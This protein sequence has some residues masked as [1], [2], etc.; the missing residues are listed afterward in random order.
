MAGPPAPARFEAAFFVSRV[1]TGS[2]WGVVVDVSI[3]GLRLNTEQMEPV[4]SQHTLF[5]IW[6]DAEFEASVEVVRHCEGGLAVRFLTTDSDRDAAIDEIIEGL[7]PRRGA[8][9]SYGDSE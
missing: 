3:T 1:E 4:G 9:P 6:G 8:D 5:F 7:T 2:T